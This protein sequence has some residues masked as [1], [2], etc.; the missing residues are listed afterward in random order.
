MQLVSFDGGVPD[1]S[2]LGG[3]KAT[4]NYVAPKSDSGADVLSLGR[5]EGRNGN[6][7]LLV[8]SVE[9]QHGLPGFW[10]LRGTGNGRGSVGNIST[11]Q[12][13]LCGGQRANRLAFYVR[14]DTGFRSASSPIS[15]CNFVVGTY[16]FDP[17]KKGVRKE[18]DNWHFYHQIILR[19]D[20][21]GDGW[22][23]V[24][25]N[26]LPQHQRGLS[27]GFPAANPTQGAGNYWELATR[28]YLD[29]H[30]YHSP[31]NIP[32]PIRMF[33]DD[34]QMSYVQPS[35]AIT[36]TIIARETQV[37]RGVTSSLRV[38]LNNTT[39]A[40]I[41]GIIGHRSRYGWTPSLTDP[42]NDK[43]IHKQKVTLLPGVNEYSL[44]VTPRQ[45]MK[46]GVS[47]LTGIVFV[48]DEQLRPNG[49][50]Q[51]DPNVRIS[52]DYAVTGPVD[53]DVTHAAIL[54]TAV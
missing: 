16:H 36:A 3:Q 13:F 52:S 19:H 38:Q 6:D 5:G 12:G 25:L 8:T 37:R 15:K 4:A 51:A 30:P 18:S 31:A 35:E 21:A 1:K 43:P 26:E 7:C 10:L 50:S 14:F 46:A 47:M 45:T 33:V 44:Q 28:L 53:C 54:L 29:C 41:S 20:L 17:S 40:P 39:S 11:N 22:I 9:P 48:P 24:V 34:V 49:Q 32:H 23:R 42:A 2:W 27:N